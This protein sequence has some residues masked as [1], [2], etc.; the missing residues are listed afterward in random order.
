[1]KFFSKHQHRLSHH[2]LLLFFAVILVTSLF[3]IDAYAASSQASISGKAYVFE[4]ENDYQFSAASEYKSTDDTTTYGSFSISGKAAVTADDGSQRDVLITPAG[5]KNGVPSFTIPEGSLSLSYSYTNTLLNAPED[6][7]HLIEDKE[8]NVDQM[9]LQNNIQKGALILQRSMDHINWSDVSIQTNVFESTP[10]QY[11]P[12]YKTLDIETINGC[13]YRLIVVYELARK[14]DDSKFLGII[15]N[16][17]FEYKRVA[18]VYEFYVSTTN[19]HIEKLNSNTPTYSLG[20]KALVE[21]SENYSGSKPMSDND[22]HRRWDLGSF[23]VSGHTDIRDSNGDVVFLKNAGDVVT[24][25]FNLSQNIDALNN[26]SKLSITSDEEGCDDYFDTPVTRFGRGMLII[27]YTDHQ[28]TPHTPVMYSDFLEACTSF[29]AN[30]RVQLFEE[31]D[32]EVALDYEVTKDQLVDKI[33]HYRIFFKFSVRN[34]NCMFFPMDL[35]TGAELTH[36]AIARN[37]FKLDAAGSKYLQFFKKREIWVEG[38]D[39]L[40]ED[41]RTNTAAKDGDI[42][43]QEGI[44]TITAKNQYTGL[45]TTKKIY[46]GTNPIL[47][48][49][50]TTN[51]S[52]AELQDL[53]SQGAVIYEDGTIE[54][55]PEVPEPEPEP[56]PETVPA[57]Q[58]AAA[59]EP[60]PETNQDQPVDDPA[61]ST[62]DSGGEENAAQITDETEPATAQRD[63][64]TL[65]AAIGATAVLAGIAAVVIRKKRSHKGESR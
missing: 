35:E 14:T 17:T 5:S 42:F 59:D 12:L 1:M 50:M 8:K 33:H 57:P 45:E 11:G 39:G 13:Y 25:W 65:V 6:D 51:Y 60:I 47:M 58:P 43:T 54:L 32:Y 22:L 48:A 64:T 49:Y 30:T 15:P 53:V 3:P 7:W 31:G 38:A 27:R 52:L 55:P 19:R 37:G 29:N 2:F 18:E 28:N 61:D 16:D 46:V 62:S 21:K 63:N 10:I 9:K 41:T 24:L 40:T 4:K 23:F 34:A 44:W 56:E 36:T 26:D 20:R